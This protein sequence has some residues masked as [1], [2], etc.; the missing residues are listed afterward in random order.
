MTTDDFDLHKEIKIHYI[1][2]VGQDAGGII[3]EWV[4]EL[5][6]V[7]MGEQM[8]LF[9]IAKGKFDMTYFP[10]KKAKEVHGEQTE[11]YFRFAG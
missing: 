1:D 10:N 8:A 7:L 4:S 5:T 11:D 3:R 6:K 2:E 9:Q